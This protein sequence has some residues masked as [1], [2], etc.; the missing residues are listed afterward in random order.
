MA[1]PRRACWIILLQLALLLPSSCLAATQGPPAGGRRGREAVLQLKIKS[2]WGDP[3]ALAGWNASA[4]AAGAHCD[5]PHVGCHTAGRVAN[6]TVASAGIMGPFPDTIGDLSALIYLDLSNNSILGG[7][8]TALYRC[9]SIED[10]DL[11][12]NNFTGQLPSDVGRRLGENLTD[13]ILF[14]NR[15]SGAIPPSLGSLKRLQT[16]DLSDNPF[17]AGELPASFKNLA[18]L[19]SLWAAG[20]NLVGEFPS[21]VLEMPELE[22]LVL[23][24]NALTG[25]IPPRV[26]SLSKLLVLGLSTNNFTGDVVV[27]GDGM[28]ARSPK[29][30]DHMHAYMYTGIIS[31]VGCGGGSAPGPSAAG[32]AT[33]V[34]RGY[35]GGFPQVTAWCRPIQRCQDING[36]GAGLAGPSALP[37]DVAMAAPLSIR[38]L[39]GPIQQVS[40]DPPPLSPVH[41]QTFRDREMICMSMMVPLHL[42]HLPVVESYGLLGCLFGPATSFYTF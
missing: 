28:A 35:F 37:E 1:P 32:H 15:F 34:Q 13:L 9:A 3:P 36:A 31:T 25:S 19:V 6:L 23:Y 7:F 40:A 30:Q 8:P 11:S 2:S 18:S 39:F 33:K 24:N 4:A 41:T 38:R 21:L 10:I 16:L 20:C 5:W 17:D 14:D 22:V 42:K 27:D 29:K 26:W 12:H